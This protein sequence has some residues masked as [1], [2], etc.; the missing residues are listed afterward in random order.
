M[1]R[2]P[3]G[4]CAWRQKVKLSIIIPVRDR[5][6]SLKRCLESL[7]ESKFRKFEVIVVDDCSQKDCSEMVR[8]YGYKAVRFEQPFDSWCARNKGAEIAVGDILV[9]LDSDVVLQPDTLNRIHNFFSLNHYA[10]LSGIY[11]EGKSHTNLATQYKNL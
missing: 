8:K 2:E 6:D 3:A 9:F 1:N 7:A 5:P 10:A 11:D 4:Q